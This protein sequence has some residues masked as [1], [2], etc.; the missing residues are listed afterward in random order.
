[1]ALTACTRRERRPAE[2]SHR[3][4]LRRR[5][6]LSSR[7]PWRG[8]PGDPAA[9]RTGCSVGESARL[10][11]RSIACFGVSAWGLAVSGSGWSNTTAHAASACS[12]SA[13]ARRCCEP[14]SAA[15]DTC[16]PRF[17]GELVHFDSFTSASSRG[18]VP[19]GT[20]RPVTPPALSG[21]LRSF[22][23]PTAA[24][25][26]AFVEQRRP[27]RLLRGVKSQIVCRRETSRR[28][29]VAPHGGAHA[30]TTFGC[31]VVSSDISRYRRS[32]HT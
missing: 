9:D 12:P 15:P 10:P 19:S 22:L 20:S 23:G 30:A 29:V 4:S 2:A 21:T 28:G 11:G 18:T 6:A 5:S 24:A 25:A 16:T 14:D 1:M 26:A 3:R 27:V 32:A 17:W 8:R 13:R 31:S 7:R